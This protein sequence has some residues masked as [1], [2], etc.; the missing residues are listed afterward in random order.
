M[1]RFIAGSAFVASLIVCGIAACAEGENAP[2]AKILL[3]VNNDERV[4]QDSKV[5]TTTF[6]VTVPTKITYVWTYH[7]N[8][9]MGK[10]PGTIALKHED[11]TVYG[12][13]K[14][15]GRKGQDNVPNANWDAEPDVVIKKGRYTV[16]DSDPSSWSHN[17]QSNNHGFVIVKGIPIPEK[18]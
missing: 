12:P 13:W 8:N 16:V 11:G 17:E 15:T 14:T 4:H 7:W 1:T 18:K 6:N 3:R 10:E 9:S 2:A 5:K